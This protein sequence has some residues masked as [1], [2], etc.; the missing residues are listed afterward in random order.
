LVAFTLAK[1]E[2]PYGKLYGSAVKTEKGTAQAIVLSTVASL[3]MQ[4]ADSML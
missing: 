4:L 3:A 1:I 2:L